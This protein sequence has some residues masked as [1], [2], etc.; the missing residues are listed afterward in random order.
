MCGILEINP[1][2]TSL[3]PTRSVR[4]CPYLQRP[5]T[6]PVFLHFLNIFAVF[7][8]FLG[9]NPRAVVCSPKLITARGQDS[10][11]TQPAGSFAVPSVCLFD[12]GQGWATH[13]QGRE[14]PQQGGWLIQ[15]NFTK[16]RKFYL[17]FRTGLPNHRA[18]DRYRC[19]RCPI[20][21]HRKPSRN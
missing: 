3:W 13:T 2:Q 10:V 8:T 12:R 6:L 7:Q 4:W 18:V 14:H 20:L 1:S 15:L 21:G 5:Y 19:L 17:Y 16:P 11:K 9:L